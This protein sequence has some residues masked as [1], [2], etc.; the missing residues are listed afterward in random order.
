MEFGLKRKEQAV[1]GSTGVYDDCKLARQKNMC[2]QKYW[3]CVTMY[4][5]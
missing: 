4:F 3:V 5:Y 1:K 2:M